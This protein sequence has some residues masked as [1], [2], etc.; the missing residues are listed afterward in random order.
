M[1]RSGGVWQGVARLGGVRFGVVRSGL[2]SLARNFYRVRR[3][4]VWHGGAWCG[5][6]RH[7]R[8]RL[9]VAWSGPVRRGTVWRGKVGH[10]LVWSGLV[11]CEV[12]NDHVVK[13]CMAQMDVVC[14]TRKDESAAS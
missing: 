2:V 13:T 8:V 5:L 12:T 9:G 7:G 11:F 1:M 4:R 10:G 14:R 6:A 3:G